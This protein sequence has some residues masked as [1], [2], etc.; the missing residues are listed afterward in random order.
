MSLKTVIA[1]LRKIKKGETVSYG[2]TW[3]A[4]R[5]SVI[6]T[7]AIGYGDGY[8]RSLS[9]Q[10][11]MLYRGQRVPIVGR[12]CMDYCMLDL[13][14]YEKFQPHVGEQVTV[15]GYSGEDTTPE[16][17]SA[18]DLAKQVNTISYELVTGVSARIPRIYLQGQ[19]HVA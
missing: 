7:V 18:E 4:L 9:N 17:L 13:T 3:K 6:A 2:A 19:S 14:D 16:L 10:G 12:V 1:A 15:W 8:P 11:W 5:D